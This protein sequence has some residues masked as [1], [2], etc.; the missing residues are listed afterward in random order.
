MDWTHW[1]IVLGAAATILEAGARLMSYV[2]STKLR[3]SWV[4]HLASGLVRLWAWL[5]PPRRPIRPRRRRVRLPAQVEPLSVMPVDPMPELPDQV[6]RPTT[7]AI[8]PGGPS[9][10]PKD[11]LDGFAQ[12][13]LAMQ[14][15]MPPKSMLEVSSGLKD[16]VASQEPI[17]KL[18]MAMNPKR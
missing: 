12:I 17:A 2:T 9:F 8:I 10:L 15:L 6:A 4:K 16:L 13:A 7:P 3:L 18:M 14:S 5:R 11:E 1:I